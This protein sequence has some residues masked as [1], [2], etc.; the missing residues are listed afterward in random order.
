LAGNKL[1]VVDSLDEAHALL[2]LSAPH[3]E[4]IE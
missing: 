2:G 1:A 4:A 3:F